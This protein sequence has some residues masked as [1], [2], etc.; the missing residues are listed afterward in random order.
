[1]SSSD[2][3]NPLAEVYDE[4]NLL[5]MV[6]RFILSRYIYKL[7]YLHGFTVCFPG[8]FSGRRIIIS[9]MEF[10]TYIY[11]LKIIYFKVPIENLGEK[12]DKLSAERSQQT[13][14]CITLKCKSII[15]SYYLVFIKNINYFR[16]KFI[17]QIST[18]QPERDSMEE[19]R[20]KVEAELKELLELRKTKDS[21]IHKIEGEKDK[22]VRELEKVQRE[23]T[24]L[25]GRETKRKND[26]KRAAADLIKLMN[27]LEK[28][29]K[30]LKDIQSIPEKSAAKIEILRES[31]V[32]LHKTE[33]ENQKQVII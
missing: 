24:E 17:Q 2:D 7:Y 9:Y 12:L 14:S 3:E 1:M 30:K 27:D 19:Q 20:T 8:G 25:E 13:Q 11:I 29:K 33:D 21:D 18:M 26:L 15:L 22:T 28:E 10:T 4:D 5:N 32:E 31:V 6:G 16:F 23:L